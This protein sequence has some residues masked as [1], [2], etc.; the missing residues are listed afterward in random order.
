MT[1]QE[2]GVQR[3]FGIIQRNVLPPLTADIV[4]LCPGGYGIA[5]RL[6]RLL[7]SLQSVAADTLGARKNN[8]DSTS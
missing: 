8:H 5:F 7:V 1:N 6:S 3:Q 4:N 2:N